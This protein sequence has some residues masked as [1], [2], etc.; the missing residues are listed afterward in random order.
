MRMGGEANEADFARPFINQFDLQR[1]VTP[2][3]FRSI[4]K[5]RMTNVIGSSYCLKK[6]DTL[7]GESSYPWTRMNLS[8]PT[9]SVAKNGNGSMKHHLE[10]CCGFDGS[11]FC[12]DF[13]NRRSLPDIHILGSS[14]MGQNT[15]VKGSTVLEFRARRVRPSSSWTISLSC[16]SSTFSGNEWCESNVGIRRGKHLK[17]S[18]ERTASGFSRIQSHIPKLGTKRDSSGPTRVA[19]RVGPRCDRFPFAQMRAGDLVASGNRPNASGA[20]T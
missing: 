6:L 5:W 8:P 9:A 15:S 12:R 18:A 20:R 4:H 16:I 11:T 13:R 3:K 10:R 1:D 7:E 17:D 19:G 2:S 14:T